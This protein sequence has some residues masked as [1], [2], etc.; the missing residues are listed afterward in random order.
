[1]TAV[2]FWQSGGRIGTEEKVKIMIRHLV[3]IKVKEQAS[4]EEINGVFDILGELKN[5][6]PGI[7]RFNAGA[8]NSPEGLAKGYTHVFIMDFSDSAARDAYLP[9]PEHKAVQGPLMEILADEEDTV[10][11]FDFEVSER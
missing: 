1:M 10:L 8:N 2:T 5:R 3:L 6:I 11:V 9:H 7:L 4:Q